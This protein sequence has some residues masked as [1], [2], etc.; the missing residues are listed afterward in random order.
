MGSGGLG[1]GGVRPFSGLT[2]LTPFPLSFFPLLAAFLVLF[3]I[4]NSYSQRIKLRL[5]G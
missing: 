1:E 2:D 4:R 5:R 3:A